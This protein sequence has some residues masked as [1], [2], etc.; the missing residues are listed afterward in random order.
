MAASVAAGAYLH[1]PAPAADAAVPPRH[2]AREAAPPAPMPAPVPPQVAQ[3]AV[4]PQAGPGGALR[5]EQQ[6][7]EDLLAQT[8]GLMQIR[9]AQIHEQL[10]ASREQFK[11][12]MSRKMQVGITQADKQR[13][14]EQARKEERARQEQRAREEEQAKQDH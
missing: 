2:H 11:R 13:A 4:P 9:L 5:N 12:T 1:F 6:E 8:R 10:R 7:L 14:A 3:P